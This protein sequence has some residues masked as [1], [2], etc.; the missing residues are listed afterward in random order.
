LITDLWVLIYPI[1]LSILYPLIK[2]FYGGKVH[3]K[4]FSIVYSLIIFLPLY[5]Y[6][7][8]K[9][10]NGSLYTYLQA[11]F[12]VIVVICHII[13]LSESLISFDSSNVGTREIIFVISYTLLVLLILV[14]P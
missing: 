14:L 11:L 5:T 12:L 2:T 4:P 13:S 9:V 7:I 8:E 10:I 6:L 1:I 3:E